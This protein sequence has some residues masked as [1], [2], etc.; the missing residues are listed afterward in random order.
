MQIVLETSDIGRMYWYYPCGQSG[1]VCYL[2]VMRAVD[3]VTQ[4]C[5]LSKIRFWIST[6]QYHAQ[7]VCVVGMLHGEQADYIKCGI[8]RRVEATQWAVLFALDAY[9]RL[10][11]AG[12]AD[13]RWWHVWDCGKFGVLEPF[14]ADASGIDPR[15]ER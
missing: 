9:R 3:G 5:I 4:Y 14:Y 11:R 15:E 2:Q 13:D 7:R 10:A 12:Q 8:A 6:H 1:A